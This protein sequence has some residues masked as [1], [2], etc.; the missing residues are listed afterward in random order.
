MLGWCM[1]ANDLE[2]RFGVYREIL[3]KN[4]RH[5]LLGSKGVLDCNC[6]CHTG[7]SKPVKRNPVARKK[8]VAPDEQ[9]VTE[10]KKRGRP[11]GSKNK[12]KVKV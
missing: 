12:P 1:D 4:C 2:Q 10:T 5:G 7:R 9:A 8:R 11:K 6:W 3:H